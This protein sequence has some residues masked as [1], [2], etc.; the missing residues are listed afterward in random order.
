M[1]VNQKRT[2][3]TPSFSIC[4]DARPCGRRDRRSPD[5]CS[6]SFPC[7]LAPLGEASRSRA[8]I[9][10]AEQLARPRVDPLELA[11]RSRAFRSRGR[12]GALPRSFWVRRY[13]QPSALAPRRSAPA[14]ARARP[15]GRGRRG[16]RPSSNAR[17]CPRLC[18]PRSRVAD[19]PPVA[20]ARRTR[21]RAPRARRGCARATARTSRCDAA[22]RSGCR[23]R[24]RARPRTCPARARRVS[25]TISMPG[26]RATVDVGRRELEA[27]VLHAAD[28]LE[29]ASTRSTRAS[30]RR[31]GARRT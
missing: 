8:R 22:R 12:I 14:S 4:F 21:D 18:W 28:L 16:Q 26:G 20:R 17:P 3:S 7:R 15:R 6:R 2:Y 27:H 19:D 11:A 25:G 5:P 10:S 30:R 29:A 23:R 13:V 24:P 9:S 31:R 1:S